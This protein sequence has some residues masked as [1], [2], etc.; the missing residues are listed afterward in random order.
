[1]GDR[2]RSGG[3]GRKSRP[4]ACAR[5][6]R[7]L[8]QRVAAL[9]PPPEP[10]AHSRACAQ[11]PWS[12]SADSAGGCAGGTRSQTC[13]DRLVQLPRSADQ[14]VARSPTPRN[15]RAHAGVWTPMTVLA[16]DTCSLARTWG[17]PSSLTNFQIAL[18]GAACPREVHHP[19]NPRRCSDG[20]A[21]APAVTR[22]RARAPRDACS[23][24]T[25]PPA[26]RARQ[27]CHAHPP[28]HARPICCVRPAPQAR[29]I[30]HA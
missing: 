5:H 25:A 12:T 8:R 6:H 14:R 13:K 10:R 2:S 3:R 24:V 30:Y 4:A 15:E 21:R 20:P 26:R 19:L 1:M 28:R 17:R 9:L 11:Q 16:L 29:R 7:R 27:R 22:C 23:S 18:A